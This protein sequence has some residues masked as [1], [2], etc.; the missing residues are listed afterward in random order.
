[1]LDDSVNDS[2]TVS[3]ESLFNITDDN[4]TLYVRGAEGDTVTLNGSWTQSTALL[5]DGISYEHYTSTAADGSLVQ[6]YIEDD[7]VIG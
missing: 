3:A 7:I 1:M 2:L 4:N 5:A 6:L